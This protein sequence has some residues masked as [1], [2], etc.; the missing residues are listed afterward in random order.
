VA[1]LGIFPLETTA[2]AG[3]VPLITPLSFDQQAHF[4]YLF[5]AN[6]PAVYRDRF[7]G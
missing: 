6:E 3:V 4:A 7:D 5:L 1:A 2:L